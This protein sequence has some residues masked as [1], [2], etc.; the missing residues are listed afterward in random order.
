[1]R[2]SAV[3]SIPTIIVLLHDIY[4]HT[5]KLRSKWDVEWGGKQDVSYLG[6]SAVL[7]VST[8]P[9]TGDIFLALSLYF[10]PP[11]TTC[12]YL[13]TSLLPVTLKTAPET[14][15][16]FFF[17][18]KFTFKILG[19]ESLNILARPEVLP[20]QEST[21]QMRQ[22]G[23]QET[24]FFSPLQQYTKKYFYNNLRKGISQLSSFI[25]IQNINMGMQQCSSSCLKI[26]V[27]PS[28]SC[29]QNSGTLMKNYFMKFWQSKDR[30]W[31][32]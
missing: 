6:Q 26:E 12:Y 15:H 5:Q 29:N 28:R 9:N 11:P 24:F 20:D 21:L 22:Y 19:T 27:S 25:R 8:F 7:E 17:S 2:N 16:S 1:M 32:Y 4:V 13:T 18:G 23:F 3:S 10:L 31:L 14:P 30:L